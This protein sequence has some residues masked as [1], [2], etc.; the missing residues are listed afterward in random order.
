VS[1]PRELA[2]EVAATLRRKRIARITDAAFLHASPAPAMRGF[3]SVGRASAA[4]D[5]E[6]ATLGAA[7]LAGLA[8]AT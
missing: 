3:A 1:A 5:L 7:E 4:A 6:R 2:E 8:L